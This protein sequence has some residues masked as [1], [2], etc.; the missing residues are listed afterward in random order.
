MKLACMIC[1][2]MIPDGGI[3]PICGTQEDLNE[4]ER[5]SSVKRE[6]IGS[7]NRKRRPVWTDPREWKGLTDKE[8]YNIGYDNKSFYEAARMVEEMLKWRNT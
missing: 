3:C 6:I 5:E 8:I 2:R 7:L 4:V 1:N